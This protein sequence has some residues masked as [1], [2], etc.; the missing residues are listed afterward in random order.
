MDKV[1]Y[2]IIALLEEN[3]KQTT[4]EIADKVGLSVS[5]TFERIKRL[6]QSGV[7]LGYHAKIDPSKRDKGLKV[8]CQVSL[9]AHNTELIQAFEEEVVHLSEVGHCYHI[10]GNYDYSLV[11]E[12]K[13]VDAYQYFLKNKLATIPNIANVQSSFVLGVIGK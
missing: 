4:K 2:Q 5:P 1:D 9:K 3:A 6:E 11:I 10:A 7:I 13:D 12:V 8:L